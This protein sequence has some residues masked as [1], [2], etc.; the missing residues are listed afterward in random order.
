L[1]RQV[2]AGELAV[3]AEAG[4]RDAQRVLR[5]AAVGARHGVAVLILGVGA[6]VAAA[7]L[8]KGAAVAEGAEGPLLVAGGEHGEVAVSVGGV[9][10]DDVDDAVDRVGA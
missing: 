10:G 3:G 8:A 2:A 1:Q 5:A 4:L 9:P 6:V 7:S